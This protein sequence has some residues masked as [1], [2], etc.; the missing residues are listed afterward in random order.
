MRVKIQWMVRPILQAQGPIRTRIAPSPTG[1]AH[2]GTAYAALFNFAFARHNKGKF[3]LRIEDTDIKRHVKGAEESIYEG[4][5]WLGISWDEGPYRQSERLALYKEKAQELKK[6]G[7]VYEQDGALYFKSPKH[8]VCW[9]DL[10]RGE[11]TFP[12]DSEQLKDFVILK[13][14]GYPTYNF[15]VVVDD[16]D[17]EISHVI[18]AEEHIS[19]TPR[20]LVIYE[21]L[22]VKPPELAHIPALRNPKRAKLSKRRDPVDLRF[23]RD[24]GYLPEA[25]VNFLCLLGWSHP[26]EKEIFTMDEFI[27]VF[28][29]SRVRKAG[30]VF[31]IQKL[32]WINKQYLMKKTPQEF[33]TLVSGA[34]IYSSEPKFSENALGTAT[35]IEPRI[36]TLKEYDTFVRPLYE[37]PV[38]NKELLGKRYKEHLSSAMETLGGL[39]LWDTEN[40]EKALTNTVESK[41]FDT[42][43]FFMDLRIA[44]T[45]SKISF[46]LND[47]IA[48]LGKE[49]VLESLKKI[50]T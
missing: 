1:F 14:D 21:S 48:R 11:I 23:W 24:E 35:L 17:M 34:S 39:S 36:S 31:D 50:L 32:K 4:L 37:R 27:K 15:A 45:G 13:S 20:Q 8:Q 29:L 9:D 46:P 2:V 3:I 6:S 38:V 26:E 10:V 22:G 49:K 19:N 41:D 40:I 42:G 5:R 18:R 43:E 25:L 47:L 33:A 12:A 44:V 16:V 7:S 30:P 28:D